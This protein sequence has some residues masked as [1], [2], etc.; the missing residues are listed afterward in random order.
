VE[1]DKRVNLDLKCKGCGYSYS[2]YSKRYDIESCPICGY[3][4][5]LQKFIEEANQTIK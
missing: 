1:V 2:V 5:E 4:A 3:R